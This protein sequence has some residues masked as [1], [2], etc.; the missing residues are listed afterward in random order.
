MGRPVVHF[1]I[2]GK[3]GKKL[4]AFYA[5]QF[6]WQIDSNNPMKY[7]VVNTGAKG[8]SRGINGG[9]FAAAKGAPPNAVTIYVS[10]DRIDPALKKIAKAGGKVVMPRTVIPGMVTFAQ[11]Q[12]PAGNVVGLVEARMPPAPKG[13]PKAKKAR[14]TK[15]GR[16]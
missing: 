8:K 11:F 4:Q 3:N 7:G 5:S 16:R 1:E 9:I 15:R 2:S 12:A 6:G 14:R 10:V 13:A